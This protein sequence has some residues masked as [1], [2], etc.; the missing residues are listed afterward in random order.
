[1][2]NFSITVLNPG[3][4]DAAQSFS[5]YAGEPGSAHAPVNYHGY[6]AC[7]AGDFETDVTAA[8]GRQRPIL[9]LIR[10]DMKAG[11]R[12]IKKIKESE[13]PVAVALK[14]S[15]SHQFASQV[16]SAKQLAL[17]KKILGLA[18]AVISPTEALIPVY[19]ALRPDKPP[20]SVCFLPTPYPFDDP[21]WDFSIPFDQRRGIFIGT[22]EFKTTSR[23]HL[24][25]LIVISELA[26]RLGQN[27]SVI[28]VDGRQTDL[29]LNEL[30]LEC[31]VETIMD[32]ADYLRCMAGHRVVFQL[33][34]S[35]V[36][37]QVSGD[38]GLC[39]SVAVGGNG[40]IDGILFP[41]FTAQGQDRLKILAKTEQLIVDNDYY[42]NALQ[43]AEQASL[44][45]NFSNSRERLETL[46]R[47]IPYLLD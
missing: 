36:P 18:D 47:S 6:A 8:V 45:I 16:D 25:G 11:L 15:G 12:A 2:S 46:F 10:R 14:E 43:A 3:G 22:R 4:T 13:L 39:R 5:D 17:L 21:R 30:G 41:D 26:K 28:N 31:Q 29:I 27:V 44:E 42:L 24:A 35:M 9:M 37:G 1:M 32:Y 19:R 34:Q 7:T 38:A 23:N 33:D 40:S 20:E